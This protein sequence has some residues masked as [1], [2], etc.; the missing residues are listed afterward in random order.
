MGGIMAE[1]SNHRAIGRALPALA[2]IAAAAAM[3][4]SAPAQAGA[5]LSYRVLHEFCKGS[6]SD[7]SFAAGDQLV[8]DVSGR[9]YGT[10]TID[11]RYDAGVIYEVFPKHDGA[12]YFK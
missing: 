3:L 9:L 7:G 4:W 10:T 6:C 11:G 8:R 5:V 2:A 1:A 12:K